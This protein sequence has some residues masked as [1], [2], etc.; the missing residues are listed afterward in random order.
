MTCEEKQYNIEANLA[1]LKLYQFNPSKFDLETTRTILLKALTSLPSNDFTLCLYLLN[2]AQHE[3]QN[4][5][6]LIE[7]YNALEQCRFED[8]WE[9]LAQDTDV[10]K[11]K[12]L[13]ESAAD[14]SGATTWAHEDVEI[15]G[16][17]ESVRS[18]VAHVIDTTYQEADATLIGSMLGGLEGAELEA[19][20]KHRGWEV[21]DGGKKFFVA[22]QEE[23]VQSKNIIETINFQSLIPLMAASQGA[24]IKK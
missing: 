8:V 22:Q 4:I 3:D 9:F 23:L 13:I 16:F 19:F 21:R 14:E 6:M 2:G 24:P 7:L 10:L 1:I 12:V 5:E 18:F 17:V 20:A 15:K 11:A